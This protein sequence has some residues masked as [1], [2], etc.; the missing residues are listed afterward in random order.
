MAQMKP[1]SIAVDTA[2]STVMTFRVIRHHFAVT[3]PAQR[4]QFTT[5]TEVSAAQC[6]LAHA[7]GDRRLNTRATKVGFSTCTFPVG[8]VGWLLYCM[9]R[10]SERNTHRSSRP[11]V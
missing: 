4:G 5:M 2:P 6:A 11:P 10:D 3:A 7:L 8:G 9:P 1:P